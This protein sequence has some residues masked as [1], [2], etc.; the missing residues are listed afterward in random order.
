MIVLETWLLEIAKGIG[1]LFLNPL[2]YWVMILF[3]ITGYKRIRKERIYF[4]MKVNDIFSEGKRTLIVSLLFSI[5]ISLLAVSFGIVFSLEIMVVLVVVMFILSITG[6]T[7]MLSASYTIGISFIL[8]LILPFVNLGSLDAYVNFNDISVIHFICLSILTGLFLL[9]ESLL[10][11]LDKNKQS[12][13]ALTLS[14]RGIW[15]GEHHLKKL[16]F[17]PFFT[18]VPTESLGGIAPLWPYF[19]YGSHSFSLI[20]FPFIIG[21]Q[22]KVRSELPESAADKLS[23]ST[24]YLSLVVL[25]VSI[26][27]LFYP[28]LSFV[29]IFIALIGKEWMTYKHRIKERKNSAYFT[30]LN[31]GVKVLAT[32]P[33]SP[34]DRLGILVGET[35]LKVNGQVVTNSSQFYEALQNSGAFFKLD[36]LDYRG[37]VRFL[38]SAFYEE[39]HHELGI[40]FPEDPNHF[41]TDAASIK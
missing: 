7:T 4:G 34:A 21:Y 26:G 16:A 5:I 15:I 10:I 39:D 1:K 36:I 17:I 41:I 31:Q 37:E 18:L 27:S 3:V 13:P 19:E 30:P 9:V 24:L 38:N 2:F 32:I 14:E 11:G 20:L 8:L 29:A 12:F 40:V 25:T 22:Y 28:F 33:N 35:I 23:Q 6:S